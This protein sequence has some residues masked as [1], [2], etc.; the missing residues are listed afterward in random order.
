MGIGVGVGAAV[1]VGVGIGF[2]LIT[3][4]L[5]DDPPGPVHSKK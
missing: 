5:P 3:C 1:G 4:F 2:T